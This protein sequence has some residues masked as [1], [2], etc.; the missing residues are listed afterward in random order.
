MI[1]Q[2]GLDAAMGA[3][4]FWAYIRR[5]TSILLQKQAQFLLTQWGFYLVGFILFHFVGEGVMQL[6]ILRNSYN[7]YRFY[8]QKNTHVFMDTKLW[9]QFQG[10]HGNHALILS[11]P[12]RLSLLRSPFCA[13]LHSKLT[14]DLKLNQPS[15][16]SL[17]VSPSTLKADRTGC[18]FF[19]KLPKPQRSLHIICNKLTSFHFHTHSFVCS[20]LGRKKSG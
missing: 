13:L 14:D 10:V 11:T 16:S 15:L 7:T 8:F 6:W 9:L 20:W 19:F 17:F 12:L 4:L 1:G 5:P 18:F 3:I 2:Q